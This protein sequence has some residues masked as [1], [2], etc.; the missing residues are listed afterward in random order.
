MVRARAGAPARSTRQ[1][2]YLA[3]SFSTN[4]S[5]DPAAQPYY[6]ISTLAWFFTIHWQTDRL[7][8]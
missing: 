6:T 4:P 1:L 2:L 5:P 8:S 3:A 7:I